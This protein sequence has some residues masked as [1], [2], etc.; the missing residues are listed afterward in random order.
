MYMYY[1]IYLYMIYVSIT[2]IHIHIYIYIEICI[3]CHYVGTWTLRA[4]KASGAWLSC[5]AVRLLPSTA[6]L[7]KN[8]EPILGSPSRKDH[9]ILGSILGPLF[10]RKSPNT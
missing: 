5:K 10:T 8:S 1:I 2:H 7:R 4:H 9:G 3:V 6:F